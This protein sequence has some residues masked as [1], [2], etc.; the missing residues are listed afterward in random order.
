M[1]LLFSN[2]LHITLLPTMK[3]YLLAHDETIMITFLNLR[4]ACLQGKLVF[5]FFQARQHDTCTCN[6]Y[7]HANHNKTDSS[8]E[9]RE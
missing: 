1:Q 9:Q 8:F 5:N 2:N 3:G 6:S 4:A 7:L